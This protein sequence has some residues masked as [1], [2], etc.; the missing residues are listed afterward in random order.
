MDWCRRSRSRACPGSEGHPVP[1]L[2]NSRRR[3]SGAGGSDPPGH[4]S[5]PQSDLS[6]PR[7]YARE[8]PNL[9]EHLAGITAANADFPNHVAASLAHSLRPSS[10]TAGVPAAA[11]GPGGAVTRLSLR[12]ERKAPNRGRDWPQRSATQPAQ[13]G[14]PTSPNCGVTAAH[15]GIAAPVRG[16]RS[17]VARN[18]C[19]SI[20]SRCVRLLQ[21]VERVVEATPRVAAGSP[22]PAAHSQ[23][24][25]DAGCAGAAAGES[26]P[27]V[28]CARDTACALADANATIQRIQD[29]SA[30]REGLRPGL[31]ETMAA[32]RDGHDQTAAVQVRDVRAGR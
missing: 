18:A 32:R 24:G 22:E 2:A 9:P 28:G 31:G 16:G 8:H 20:S 19:G 29:F 12:G 17:E 21:R 23:S 30:I 4:I 7:T 26:P 11:G 15:P 5:H 3:S 27:A 1:T 6:A 14:G 25:P 10:P 13:A